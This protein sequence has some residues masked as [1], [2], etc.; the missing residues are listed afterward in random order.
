MRATRF[1]EFDTKPFRCNQ[2][3]ELDA[4]DTQEQIWKDRVYFWM[5]ASYIALLTKDVVRLGLYHK[6]ISEELPFYASKEF[7]SIDRSGLIFDLRQK[8]YSVFYQYFYFEE[9]E[10]KAQTIL[11]NYIKNS[12]GITDIKNLDLSIDRT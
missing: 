7:L 6:F 2:L 8:I 4:F 10:K 3:I 11:E 9:A 12:Y 5:A 1:P